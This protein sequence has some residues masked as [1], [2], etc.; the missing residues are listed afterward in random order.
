MQQFVM[1]FCCQFGHFP[2]T[3]SGAYEN[4]N[5]QLDVLWT[6]GNGRSLLQML[7]QAMDGKVYEVT[8]DALIYRFL[9][10][11]APMT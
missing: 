3:F 7:F 1:T 10:S 11:P 2:I 9:D 5:S 6:A 4:D 8:A